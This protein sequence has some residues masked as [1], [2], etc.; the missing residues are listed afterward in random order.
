[1]SSIHLENMLTLSREGA[2]ILP[3]MPA[4]Y[5]HPETLEDM[6]E[7][8]VSRVLDQIGQV[9]SRVEAYAR[10]RRKEYGQSD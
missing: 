5:H 6:V 2:I 10:K 1:M 9:S 8:F 4:F 7:H 3:A